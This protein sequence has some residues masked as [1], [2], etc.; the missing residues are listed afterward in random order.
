MRVNCAAGFVARFNL[1]WPRII[2]KTEFLE[3]IGTTFVRRADSKTG[4]LTLVT[5][6]ALTAGRTKTNP[7]GHGP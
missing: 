6:G 2:V 1:T 7:R 3:E 4:S 5:L